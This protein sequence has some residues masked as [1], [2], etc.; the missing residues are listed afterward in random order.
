MHSLLKLLV[1]LSITLNSAA[2]SA[3]KKVLQ[4]GQSQMLL[5]CEDE[6]KNPITLLNSILLQKKFVL[7]GVEIEAP[8]QASS[9]ALTTIGNHHDFCAAVTITKL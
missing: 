4:K 1:G 3:A 9:P 2:S 5:N 7:E 8:F 6:G